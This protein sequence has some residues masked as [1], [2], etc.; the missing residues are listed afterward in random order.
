MFSARPSRPA[1]TSPPARSTSTTSSSARW[2][3]SG[4]AP[5]TLER[6]LGHWVLDTPRSPAYFLWRLTAQGGQSTEGMV[7]PPCAVSHG[8]VFFS[9]RVSPSC[10]LPGGE[11]AS[12][13]LVQ[14]HHLSRAIAARGREKCRKIAAPKRFLH[15]QHFSL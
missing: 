7:P 14:L 5:G 1:R 3:G 8:R 4:R 6:P 11:W 12:G 2:R 9:R 10:E 13:A 15:L